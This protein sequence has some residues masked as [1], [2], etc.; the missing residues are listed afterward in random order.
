MRTKEEI[1][2][3]Q[4]ACNGL[5]RVYGIACPQLT[6]DGI[7]GPKTKAVTN[8]LFGAASPPSLAFE[9]CG[10]PIIGPVAPWGEIPV[11][12]GSASTF[13]GP[14]DVYDHHYGQAFLADPAR[15]CDIPAAM[16]KLTA[17]G[18]F[19]HEAL[20]MDEYPE[21]KD[22][23]FGLSWALDPQSFYCALRANKS[24]LRAAGRL[25][26]N[27]AKV[28]FVSLDLSRAVVC[29]LTDFGPALE[30]GCSVDLSPAAFDYLGLSYKS[31]CYL[32]WAADDAA[33]G[34]Y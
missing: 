16:P 30:T 4:T 22:G 9:S 26:D 28:A 13:G 31:K 29:F 2:T 15:P 18:L 27:P 6:V 23:K 14:A 1:K 5:L 33:I 25:G 10:L 12:I 8:L 11:A 17:A 20:E 7:E 32:V 34:C 24:L 3:L 19:R 21:D